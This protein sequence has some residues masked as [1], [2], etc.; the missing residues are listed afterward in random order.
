M[1]ETYCGKTCDNCT[2]KE[3]LN[4]PGCKSGPGKVFSKDCSIASCCREKGHDSC[5]SCSFKVDCMSLRNRYTKAEIRK[6]ERDAELERQKETDTR[7]LA[8]GKW[9]W[10]LF[11][12][13]I[14]STIAGILTLNFVAQ[15]V[16]IVYRVGEI[17]KIVVALLYGAILLKLSSAEEKYKKAGIYQLVAVAGTLLNMLIWGGTEDAPGQLFTSLPFGIISLYGTYFEFMAHSSVLIGIDN[18]LSED[19][20]DLWKRVLGA[21]IGI[22]G[23]SIFMIVSLILGGIIVIA[24]AVYLIIVSIFTLMYLHRTAVV[25]RDY[26]A[27]DEK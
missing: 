15:K 26:T 23:G 14:P 8:I 24:A 6:K 1:G 7:A 11:L 16:P 20:V 13:I 19:W 2:W 10:F 22:I 9:L 5:D 27:G 21:N 4:C 12:L 18:R 17:L 3:A 25:F